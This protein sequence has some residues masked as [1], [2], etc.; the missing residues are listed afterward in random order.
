MAVRYYSSTAAETT[1]S[2]TIN[3]SATNITVGSTT[4]FPVSFPYTL[5]LDYEGAS[6]E[7]VDVTAA[8]GTNLTIVRAADGTSATS[9][10]AG[11]RVR[12]VSS[13]RDFRDSRTHEENVAGVHGLSGN[14]VGTTDTQTLSNKTLIN[15][16]GTLNR[17]DILSEGGTAWQTT[18]NGDIDFNTNLTQWKRGPSEPHEVATLRNNGALYVR[19]QDAAAD[20]VYNTYRFRATKDDGST[21]IFYVLSGGEVK[22]LQDAGQ[23]GMTVQPRADNST[24]RAFGVRNAANSAT[25]FAVMQDGRVD[26]NGT[27]PAFSQFDITAPAGQSAD[28]M[29][30]MDNGGNTRFAVQSTGRAL[31]NRGMT[32]AQPGLTSGAVL[33]VG[34]T[35]AGYT[36]NLQ[37][38]VSPSNTIVANIDQNGRA[39]FGQETATGTS[40]VTA[41]AG[42]SVNS[43]TIGVKKA[44]W[45]FIRIILER[46]G[47]SLIANSK[48]NI[49]DTAACTVAAAWRPDSVLGSTDTVFPMG[50]S[51]T[52]GMVRLL[53]STGLVELTDLHSGSEIRNGDIVRITLQ[54]PA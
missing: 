29:R 31:A 35:N 11:A 17:I 25:L 44:G 19:N 5:A 45:I 3:S 34:G 36:G 50:A 43:A 38:W 41:A 27:N 8:A 54:Y 47:G 12:H 6:E 4:G 37:Q 21:D 20:S 22:A 40:V 30:V 33:Q 15:A 49:T 32:V 1:L 42:F 23:N 46:T 26:I 13:A 28:M 52:S 18:I 53:P 2:G 48:G 9:H 7:L 14:V 51:V 16:T 24:S 39:E 10:S